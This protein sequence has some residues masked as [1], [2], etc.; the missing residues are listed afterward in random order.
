MEEEKIYYTKI[1][2]EC[3]DSRNDWNILINV[4]S[5]EAAFQ[6]LKWIGGKEKVVENIPVKLTDEDITELLPY[7]NALDFEAYR[8]VDDSKEWFIYDA[9]VLK[10]IGITN[11]YL[12]L[13]QHYIYY[14]DNRKD[15]RPYE[16]LYSYVIKKYFSS[17]I[18]KYF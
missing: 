17:L 16:K 7:I 1:I 13:Y 18:G 5:R 11:S 12:P 4:I 9:P 8:Y 15:K 2:F 10:F 6:S 3:R 14:N